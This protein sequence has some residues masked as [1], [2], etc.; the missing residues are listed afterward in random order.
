ML[1][2]SHESLVQDCKLC[3]VYA[4]VSTLINTKRTAITNFNANSNSTL[5]GKLNKA[6]NEL[7]T[8]FKVTQQELFN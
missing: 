1:I 6:I 5:I 4:S 7:K 2:Q 8:T 3:A